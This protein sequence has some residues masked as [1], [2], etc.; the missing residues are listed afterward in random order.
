MKLGGIF[1]PRC[2]RESGVGPGPG[3]CQKLNFYPPLP[4][5][6][7]AHR[8][9]G[10]GAPEGNAKDVKEAF[11]AFMAEAFADFPILSSPGKRE[12]KAYNM[13]R[14]GGGSPFTQRLGASIGSGSATGRILHENSCTRI[15]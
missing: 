3:G 13:F 12:F 8:G 1:S 15:Q 9:V 11:T 2:G 5:P 10:T 7:V 4:P 14:P 6:V